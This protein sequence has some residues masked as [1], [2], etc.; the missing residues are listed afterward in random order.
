MKVPDFD[1]DGDIDMRDYYDDLGGAYHFAPDEIRPENTQLT[2]CEQKAV[3]IISFI[4]G[5]AA[6]VLLFWLF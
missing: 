3:C 5:L 4:I 2:G 1:H 6:I